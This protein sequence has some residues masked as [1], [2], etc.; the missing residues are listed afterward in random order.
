M[1]ILV[2]CLWRFARAY[3]V[4][5]KCFFVWFRSGQFAMMLLSTTDLI[6][7][8]VVVSSSI[9]IHR[10]GHCPCGVKLVQKA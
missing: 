9:T 6:Q 5:P 8:N 1:T 4:I 2:S 3:R 10:Y 7:D